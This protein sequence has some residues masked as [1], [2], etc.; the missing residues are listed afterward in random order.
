ML[1]EAILVKEKGS[2]SAALARL[3]KVLKEIPFLARASMAPE[4]LPKN[5][6]V[7]II[8]SLH[9]KMPARSRALDRRLICDVRTS[10]QPR[11][12]REA[13]L[14][15]AESVRMDKR[16]YP[17][18]IA[19]YIS[20]ASAAICGD[21]DTGYLDFAGNC[22]LTFDTIF[23]RREGF[24]NTAVQKRDLRSLYS[25][26]AERVLRVLLAS[27]KRTWRTQELAGA[28]GV[29]LGQVASIKKLLADR[30]WIDV[31]P[32]G[33]GLRPFDKAV[34][35]L[36][37]EWGRNYRSDR[38]SA[39]DFYSLKSIPEVEAGLAAAAKSLKVPIAFTGF[40]GAA[41]FAPA[42]RYQRVT[43]YVAGDVDAVAK[44]LGLKPV[45]SGANVTL[46]KPYDEGVFFGT[47]KLE[48]APVVS[49]VQIYLDLIQ[50]KGRGEEAA[51]AMLKD[52]IKPLW[53]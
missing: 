42:V 12:A 4:R 17:V 44:N 40:S 28:A 41:R 50:N 16:A 5:T 25:P 19:P 10:G 6:I 27:G 39:G 3:K 53:R 37:E 14:H 31:L 36:L 11:V 43:A 34:L 32:A 45:P 7:D 21:Y 38:N 18:F 48:G 51:S 29:S 9:S 35:P 49:P 26:K 47:R 52:V 2:V 33:F 30:E 24:P 1:K 23:I 13:C 22:R 8:L 46:I 20:P 15:L